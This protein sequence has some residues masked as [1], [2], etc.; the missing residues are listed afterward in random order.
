MEWWS[1]KIMGHSLLQEKWDLTL[2][3]L[4]IGRGIVLDDG[5]FSLHGV[6]SFWYLGNHSKTPL[7]EISS[8]GD[9]RSG[10]PFHQLLRKQR[11]FEEII[12]EENRGLTSECYGL[13]YS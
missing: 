7:K 10:C 9:C 11:D 3:S 5:A 1:K 12:F 8:K 4:P 6:Y 13:Y 2:R